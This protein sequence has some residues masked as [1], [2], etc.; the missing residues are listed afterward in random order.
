MDDEQ[1]KQTPSWRER[2]WVV[3]IALVVLSVLIPGYLDLRRR[4]LNASCLSNMREISSALRTYM[5]D[6]DETI[7][8]AYYRD[9]KSGGKL[10][11][12]T[13]LIGG[14]IDVKRLYCPADPDKQAPPYLD[15]DSGQ[16][17]HVSYGFFL[18][19]SGV[20]PSRLAA[21]GSQLAVIADSSSQG[22][23]THPIPG[24]PAEQQALF[25]GFD[26][27]DNRSSEGAQYVQRLAIF[28]RDN[29]WKAPSRLRTRHGNTINML[30]AD[31]H[32][33]EVPA[34]VLYVQRDAQ[35]NVLPPWGVNLLQ[36]HED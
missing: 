34:S 28:P 12:W 11:T 8:L 19:A 2:L 5:L 29:Q 21:T 25:I 23:N 3:G 30:F 31:G 10:V 18:G 6:W 16:K 9:E 4:S 17:Q 33:G 35:G 20:R 1:R 15:P 26:T 32:V 7:P 13:M 24:I 27:P 22:L 36:E 14:Y